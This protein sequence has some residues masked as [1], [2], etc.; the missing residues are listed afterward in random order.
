MAA[1]VGALADLAYPKAVLT[2]LQDPTYMLALEDG[3]RAAL[4]EQPGESPRRL[5]SSGSRLQLTGC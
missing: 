2:Q 1:F 4:D 5:T 3:I